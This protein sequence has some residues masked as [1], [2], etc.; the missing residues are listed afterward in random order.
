LP[1]DYHK[2]RN[3]R[4]AVQQRSYSRE[5]AVRFAR[6][7]GAGLPGPLAADDGRFIGS[8]DVKALPM[9]AVALA[10]GEFWQRDPEAGLHWTQIVHAEE[11]ITL[12][13]PLPVAG[14]VAVERR[15]VDIYDRG[16]EKGAMLLE[17]QVLRNEHGDAV[18]TIDVVTVLRGD[19]GFGGTSQGAPRPRPVPSDRAPDLTLDLATPSQDQPVFQ[20]SSEFDVTTSLSGAKPGQLMLRGVCA[21]GLAGRA[22]LALICANEPER[23]R[24]LLV[25]YAGPLLT[26]ETARIELWHTGKGRASFRMHAMER[27]APVLNHCYAE[28]DT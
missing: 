16:V 8:G 5:D 15:I 24:R 19:G 28:F 10:D 26:D 25:R 6:G 7:F 21:F 2:I 1:L 9:I 3:W 11:A 20:L 14:I 13:R 4:F 18:V 27:N 22:V 23:L 12:H 17:Q